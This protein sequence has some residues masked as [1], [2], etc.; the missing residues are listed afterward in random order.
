MP[1]TQ[2]VLL[3]LQVCWENWFVMLR[4]NRLSDRYHVDR[5]RMDLY[6]IYV[7]HGVKVDEYEDKSTFQPY[8]QVPD[9]LRVAPIWQLVL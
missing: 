7:Y 4:I 1:D 5:R 6:L 9:R 2:Y 3:Q 8:F